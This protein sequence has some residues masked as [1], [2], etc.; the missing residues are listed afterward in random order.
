M[1][2]FIAFCAGGICG[3]VLLGITLYQAPDPPAAPQ[4]LEPEIRIVSVKE[5]P[6]AAHVKAVI[7]C[8]DGKKM[9]AIYT[10][11]ELHPIGEC[12]ATQE[13][14]LPTP[15]LDNQQERKRSSK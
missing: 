5:I 13:Q 15:I 7:F 1:K 11:S 10:R 4:D 9:A 14:K 12:P 2:T 8:I 3:I 6:S